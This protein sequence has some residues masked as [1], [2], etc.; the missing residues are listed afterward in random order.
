MPLHLSDN[1]QSSATPILQP[2][3]A[4]P[5]TTFGRGGT[6]NLPTDALSVNQLLDPSVMI[7]RRAR[8]RLADRLR[9][10][11]TAQITNDAFEDSAVRSK[12]VAVGEIEW[13]LAWSHYDDMHEHRLTAEL[14]LTDGIRRDFARA[15]LFLKTDLEYEWGHWQGMRGFLNSAFHLRP[16][17]RT[18]PIRTEGG[19]IRYWP[20]LR[21]ADYIA[22]RK[23]P[24]YLTGKNVQIAAHKPPPAV[25]SSSS[26]IHQP[27]DLQPAPALRSR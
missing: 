11:A 20:F 13:R 8:N 2:S 21:R 17:R 14:T 10:L 5:F 3:K 27:L 19:D 12:D 9:H 16:L 15:I 26:A 7:D 22:S 18:P 23:S 4:S 6:N 24:V 25:P 1:W